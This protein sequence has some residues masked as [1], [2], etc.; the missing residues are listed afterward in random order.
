[1]HCRWQTG[2]AAHDCA[3]Q[4]EGGRTHPGSGPVIFQCSHAL[5]QLVGAVQC[6]QQPHAQQLQALG[7]G[8]WGKVLVQGDQGVSLP[9]PLL[10][11][12]PNAQGI[13]LLEGG[14]EAGLSASPSSR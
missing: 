3:V 5:L 6:I 12:A 10:H 11:Y 13:L 1:M 9:D 4:R 8:V 14:L 7:P 2:Q